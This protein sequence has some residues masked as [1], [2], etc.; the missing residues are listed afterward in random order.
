VT[1]VA[2]AELAGHAFL[3]GLTAQQ[4]ARLA[5]VATAIAVPAGHR[6]FHE[7][8][9]AT[10]FWLIRTGQV[11]LDLQVPGRPR[12]IVETLGPGDELG[13]SWLSESMQWQ[14]GAAAQV[15][16]TAFELDGPAVRGLCERD[17]ELGWE[18][19]RRMLTVASGRLQAA[20]IRL[21]DLYSSPVQGPGSPR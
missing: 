21:V 18:L 2:P 10:R 12:L 5:E 1:G 11:A 4:A 6:F 19:A 8:G 20:R 15:P 9:Q 7:G 17:C 3:R 16:T 13:L 14:L